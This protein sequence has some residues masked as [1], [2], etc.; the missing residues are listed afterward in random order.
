LGYDP[1]VRDDRAADDDNATLDEPAGS[2]RIGSAVV[3]GGAGFIG[4]HLVERL[5]AEGVSVASV[6]RDPRG[7]VEDLKATSIQADAGSGDRTLAEHLA[8]DD[9]HA[10]FIL[11]GTGFVPLSLANPK[12]DLENNVL[13]LLAVLE[14]LRA[15][16]E[17]PVVVYFSSAAVY[18]DAQ[19]PP[20]SERGPTE[21]L[22]PY[23]VSKLAGEGYVRLYQRL[24]GIPALSLRPF[25]V[26]GPGQRKLVV[27]DLLRRM[28]LLEDPLMVRGEAGVTRDYVFVGD[29]VGSAL[30][31]ARMAPAEGEAYNVCSGLG[32]SLGDLAQHLL[33]AARI[34]AHVQ[35][36]GDLR[37]GD[38]VRFLGD[39]QAMTALGAGCPTPLPEGLRTT[40]E[41]IR[42]Q[43]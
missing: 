22:S 15:R 33:A 10:V 19:S 18:G 3:I 41:W 32:T 1:P 39:P 40:V 24:Y 29:V 4:R 27:Y 9:V 8:A 43:K 36:S 20:M 38:P 13:T 17:P 34:D 16:R 11:V 26:Y 31:L 23:G 28:L 7:R 12:A 42:G 14:C 37:I 35:F 25:S 2:R 21:P 6:D 30:R 5:V